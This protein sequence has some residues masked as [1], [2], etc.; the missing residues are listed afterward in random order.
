[1]I[2]A[3]GGSPI[4]YFVLAT[5]LY[6]LTPTPASS[7]PP[8][9]DHDYTPTQ[10][11]RLIW[12]M[13][14][15]LEAIRIFTG[16]PREEVADLEIQGAQARE[17]YFQA[18]NL[19]HKADRLALEFTRTTLELDPQPDT[20]A[21]DWD[22]IHPIIQASLQ[23]IDA[24]V[25]ELHIVAPFEVQAPP[26]QASISEV[27][28]A[29]LQSNQR[30]NQLLEDPIT[31]SEVY[32]QVTQ[33]LHFAQ[34]LFERFP[35]ERRLIPPPEWVAGKRPS[36]V[37][38]ELFECYALVRSIAKQSSIEIMAVSPTPKATPYRPG[39]VYDIATLLRSE[40]TYIHAMVPGLSTPAESYT[41][42]RKFP[43][44]VYQR[45][46]QLNRTL[47]RLN[48]LISQTPNWL[49]ETTS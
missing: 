49:E 34:T 19:Y 16:K 20:S 10:S 48:E 18:I 26:S 47:T 38:R 17:T 13:N 22:D 15:R 21:I 2:E 44:D 33:A 40:L 30:I 4:H 41:P 3:F 35:K 27:Y 32:Q 37:Y 29:I 45:A 9:A 5:C 36:D 28:E 25:K 23:R 43:S 8:S 6:A 39:E 12:T 11:L 31:P 42:G 24:V 46:R 14:E 7:T 1:M